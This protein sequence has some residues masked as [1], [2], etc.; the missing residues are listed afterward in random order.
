MGPGTWE[1]LD[2]AGPPAPA[3]VRGTAPGG[4]VGRS[5]VRADRGGLGAGGHM[6]GN[7]IGT[8]SSATLIEQVVVGW[9][10]G[11]EPPRRRQLAPPPLG[12]TANR[13][14]ISASV[15]E[16]L[17]DGEYEGRAPVLFLEGYGGIGKTTVALQTCWLPEV[18]ERF[19]GGVVWTVIGQSRTGPELADHI[20]DICEHLSGRRPTSTDPLLVGALL[21]EILDEGGPALVVVDDVWTEEQVNAFLVGGTGSARM[22]TARNRG[23]APAVA[24]IVEVGQMTEDEARATAS[25]GL[26]ELDASVLES[27][28]RFAKGWPVLLGLINASLRAHIRA[29][30]PPAEVAAWVAHLVAS[31]GPEAL[32]ATMPPHMRSTVAATVSASLDLLSAEERERYFDLAVFDEDAEVPEHVVALL[33]SVTGGL[34]R[35]E[36]RRMTALL[37]TLRLVSQ[38]W[39]DGEP[40]IAVH[41]VLRSYVRHQMSPQDLVTRNR[42]L[43]AALRTLLPAG[44]AAQWWLLPP[45]EEFALQYLPYHLQAAALHA[46]LCEL[47]C[48]PRWIESQIRHLGSVVLAVSTLSGIDTARAAALRAVLDR[49]VEVFVPEAAPSAVGAT[50][51]SRLAG[52]AELDGVVERYLEGMARPLLR[53]HWPLPDT[54]AATDD[55]HTG[56]IGDCAVSPRGDVIATASD[57]RLVILWD[58]ATLR[59]RHVLRGHSQRVRACAFSPDGSRLLSAATDGT[60]RI[61]NVLDGRPLHVLGEHSARVLGCAWSPDGGWVASTTGDGTV[62]IWDARTGEKRREM[63]SPSGN[64]WD[65]AFTPDGDGLVSVGED[66]VLRMWDTASGVARWSTV[67]HEGR[68]RCCTVAPSGAL[69][70]TAGS[71]ATV[72]VLRTGTGELVHV[73]RAHTDRVRACAFSPDGTLLA[74]AS[75]DRTIR[76][77]DTASGRQV[78]VLH[79]HTDWVGAS[80]FTADGGTLI[81][82]GGDTTLRTWDV[83]ADTPPRTVRATRRAVGCCAFSADGRHVVAGHSDGVVQL[84]DIATGRVRFE[85]DGHDG[86]VLDCAVTP[87]GDVV[88]AGAD[89]DLA[90][91]AAPS[92]DLRRRFKRHSGRVWGCAVSPDGTRM[93]SAGE[94]AVVRVHDLRT[95][96]VLGELVNHDGHVLGCAFSPDGELIASVGDD[97]TLRLWDSRTG[98]LRSTLATGRESSLWRC[99]FSPDGTLLASVGSPATALTLWSTA[100]RTVGTS[101]PIGGD[102]ITGCAFSP[103]G[104]Q[105]ATCGD[106]GY[107]GVWDVATGTPLTGIRVAYPLHRCAWSA[108]GTGTGTGTG[109][110]IAA[111]GNG[112]LYLFAYEDD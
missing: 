44:A 78:R 99:C 66:G 51:A 24:R 40:A 32:D 49:D 35:T 61:W 73:L 12:E 55:G 18:A 96:E 25:A 54:D 71:D 83:T 69:M 6:M 74:S 81:S 5:E 97:G 47:A 10:P 41:D 109:S 8:G 17:S 46:E 57:D 80:V 26:P 112:G 56:P 20:A 27:L 52:T 38:R 85:V 82:C 23:L 9:P 36:S 22:F 67:V 84:F 104:R 94:D 75:E 42:S 65:C 33:W 70:A 107:L 11:P 43:V 86:R 4:P 30:G 37:S 34:E 39:C 90:L 68:I 92:G 72:R 98:H 91:W 59:V 95:T 111:A 53:A 28:L 106:E 31:D 105:I 101:V 2:P 103:S 100:D 79:G 1:G 77:W 102:R 93:A 110:M 87:D 48:D 3:P 50:L 13:A 108:A 60:V 63:H 21:G 45:R 29:G 89:G 16:A 19:P 64:E 58:A 15:E 88:T 76:L 14:G 7:A 62:T